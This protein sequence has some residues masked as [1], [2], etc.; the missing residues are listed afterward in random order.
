MS[1][2]GVVKR[3][4]AL[5]VLPVL[6]LGLAACGGGSSSGSRSDATPAATTGGT[7]A[8]VPAV[9]KPSTHPAAHGGRVAGHEGG[10]GPAA[11]FVRPGA[12][13]SIPTYGTE[14]SAAVRHGAAAA[15][16]NYL[17]ARASGNWT[18]ACSYLGAAMRDQISALVHA[19]S[20]KVKDCTS[21]FAK[22]ASQGESNIDPFQGSIAVL[23]VRGN[24]AFA[25]FYG[26]HRRQYMMPMAHEGGHW[27]VNQLQAIPY[28]PG[29]PGG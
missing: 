4:A 29:S 1:S 16:G 2:P 8:S 20:G 10:R 24:Q 17:A 21:I 14:G 28:P 7:T 12:D 15:L 23:R 9:T 27:L 11:A 26:P 19:S 5:A 13:N 18:V 3:A 22:A 6:A 25:L